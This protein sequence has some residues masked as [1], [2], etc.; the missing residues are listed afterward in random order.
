MK[1]FLIVLTI[2]IVANFGCKKEQIGDGICACSPV[3]YPYLSLAIKNNMGQDL[4]S[5]GIAGA[6]TSDQI[7]L[8]QKNNNGTIKLLKFHIRPP[9]SYGNDQFKYNLLFSEEIIMLTKTMDQTFYLKLGDQPAFELNLQLH[10]TSK[11]VERLLIN[12]NEAILDKGSVA[13]YLNIF[14]LTM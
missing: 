2:I 7:Q 13:A 10:T 9:F 3:S 14:Y 1:K 4:L 11:K 12:K 6:Y 5:A 8:F